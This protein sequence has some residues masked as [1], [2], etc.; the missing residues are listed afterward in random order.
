MP[1]VLEMFTNA[2]KTVSRAFQSRTIPKV[3]RTQEPPKK[4]HRTDSKNF[5]AETPFH[6]TADNGVEASQTYHY[7]LRDGKYILGAS[8]MTTAFDHSQQF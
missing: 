3:R 2:L 1:S 8:K 7:E 6:S 4:K 5:E